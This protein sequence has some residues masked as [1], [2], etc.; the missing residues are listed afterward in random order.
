MSLSQSTGPS[1]DSTTTLDLFPPLSS[2]KAHRRA[3]TDYGNDM[4]HLLS[5]FTMDYIG[6]EANDHIGSSSDRKDRSRA[7]GH[8]SPRPCTAC[9]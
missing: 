4:L 3:L 9:S 1:V 7:A 2:Q 8:E 5:S 6:E